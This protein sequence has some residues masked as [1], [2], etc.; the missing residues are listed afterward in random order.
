MQLWFGWMGF[1]EGKNVCF[2]NYQ[3]DTAYS[4]KYDRLCTSLPD[5]GASKFGRA[6]AAA[7]R[8]ARAEGKALTDISHLA[9]P[10]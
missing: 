5:E 8:R 6:A 9:A 4:K 1:Y 7:S 10:Y 2:V 3:G